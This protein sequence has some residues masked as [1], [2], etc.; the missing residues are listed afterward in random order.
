MAESDAMRDFVAAPRERVRT[1]IASIF[2][3]V[4]LTQIGASMPHGA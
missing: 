3:F 1:N 4:F 2:G